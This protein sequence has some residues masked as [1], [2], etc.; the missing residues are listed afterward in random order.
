MN[1]E[2]KG[3]ALLARIEQELEKIETRGDLA[4]FVALLAEGI[5]AK[6]FEDQGLVDYV[7]GIYGVVDGLEGLAKNTGIPN[8]DPPDWKLVGRILFYGFYHS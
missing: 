4:R 5:Q 7:D 6:A 3:D 8:P 1:E 2:R